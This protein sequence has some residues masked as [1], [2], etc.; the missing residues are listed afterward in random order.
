MEEQLAA[1]LRDLQKKARVARRQRARLLERVAAS[2]A[3][4]LVVE[5]GIQVQNEL[6]R[7]QKKP[8]GA[9]TVRTS[10]TWYK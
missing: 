8:D 2:D 10:T 6:K 1:G 9:S 4:C 5:A 3:Q 7:K